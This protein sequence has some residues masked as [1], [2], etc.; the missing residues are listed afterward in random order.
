MISLAYFGE[1][2]SVEQ[3]RAMREQAQRDVEAKDDQVH[4]YA[5]SFC[6]EY[7]TDARSVLSYLAWDRPRVEAAV[8]NAGVPVA[9][10]YGD[11]DDRV[12]PEWLQTMVSSGVTVRSVAG[13]NH[14]FDLTHEFELFDQVLDALR[15][16]R[17]G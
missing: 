13:A 2:Q 17:H 8:K 16:V 7:V 11:K 3:I 6:D 14:F 9:V 5:M 10:I 12:N 4:S 1:E 15:E